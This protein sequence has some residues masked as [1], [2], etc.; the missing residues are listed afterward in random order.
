MDL[1]GVD[2]S[3]YAVGGGGFAL[4]AQSLWQRF[5]SPDGKAND[6]LVSQL[7][8]RLTALETRQSKLESDLDDERKQRRRA[9]DKVHALE[10][11]NLQLRAVLKNHNIEVPVSF[12]VQDAPA[13]TGDAT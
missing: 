12:V 3:V 9:E 1:S 7:T 6:A 11:D 4:I 10:L 5:V 13:P 8:E 2:Q